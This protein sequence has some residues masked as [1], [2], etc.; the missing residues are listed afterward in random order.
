MEV[1]VNGATATRI[2]FESTSRWLELVLPGADRQ[3]DIRIL[4]KDN[5]LLTTDPEKIRLSVYDDSETVI[6]AG[7]FPDPG[8]G[9]EI[10]KREDGA[11]YYLLTSDEKSLKEYMLFWNIYIGTGYT[12]LD[13]FQYA[14]IARVRALMLLPNLRNQLDKSQKDVNETYGWA[15]D[16]LYLLLDGAVQEINKANTRVN[17][18][19]GNFP[20]DNWW[21]L[22]ID[23]ATILGL[24]SQGIFSIDSDLTYT[25]QGI[26]FTVA[27]SGD[28]N[29]YLGVLLARFNESTKAFGL[30]H[31]QR[32]SLLMEMPRK[33]YGKWALVQAAPFGG[34]F[35]RIFGRY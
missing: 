28:I 13:V 30:R 14:K 6:Y 20:I 8:S 7:E 10:K 26:T 33:S 24:I 3:M 29:T 9:T 31:W 5:Q 34:G 4:D 22:L 11:Y 12:N 23:G 2:G 32:P 1:Q 35:P 27:H 17:Y 21:Q 16:Q 18:T 19:L 25:D 15:D